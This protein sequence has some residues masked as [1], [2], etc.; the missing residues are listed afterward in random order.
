M[1]TN[2]ARIIVALCSSA[3]AS[4]APPRAKLYA[5]PALSTAATARAACA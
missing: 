4:D 5:A 1:T 3:L 2:S